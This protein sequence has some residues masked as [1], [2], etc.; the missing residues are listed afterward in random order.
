MPEL[1]SMLIFFKLKEFSN[2]VYYIPSSSS[3]ALWR[4]DMSSPHDQ[5]AGK[6]IFL[7]VSTLC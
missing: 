2:P 7:P 4:K 1:L 6:P 3:R 5:G